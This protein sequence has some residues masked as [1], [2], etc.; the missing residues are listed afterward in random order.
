MTRLL[1]L[2]GA[3]LGSWIWDRVLPHLTVPAEALDLPGRT[4]PGEVTLEQCIDAVARK[5]DASC[6]LVGHSISAEIALAVA[7]RKPVAGVVLVGGV[8]PESGRDFLSTLP[9]P[10]RLFLR[11]LL[12]RARNGIALPKSG[13]RKGYCNDLDDAT[14]E[15][16]LSRVVP[17]APR[18]YLDSVEWTAGPA[19]SYVKLLNDKSVS[20]KQQERFIERVGAMHV[21]SLNTGHL[22]MLAQPREL[23]AILNR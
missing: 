1:L 21:D 6:V 7:T 4:N 18:L 13:V 3:G 17:E 2:H 12:R 10:Q 16:V 8:V 22:P 23:A 5:A 14:T 11:V 15:L 19:T 9:L 20:V